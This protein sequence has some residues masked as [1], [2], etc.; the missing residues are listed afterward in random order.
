MSFPPANRAT[1]L[2]EAFRACDAGPLKGES[3]T[4]Y[5]VDLS[6]VRSA[7]TIQS[8]NTQLDFLEPGQF[9]A[10]A[11]TGHRGCG[12]STELRRLQQHWQT[13]YRVI[14]LEADEEL[15]ISDVEFVD[16]YLLTLKQV[17]DDLTQLDLMLGVPLQEEFESWLRD[18]T[19]ASADEF[20]DTTRRSLKSAVEQ[21]EVHPE[22]T[23]QISTLS[24]LLAKLLAQIKGLSQQRQVIRQTLEQT[25]DRLKFD[26]NCLLKH[27]DEKIRQ[28][29][30]KGFLLIFDNLD[31]VPLSV[32]ERLFFDSAIHLQELN[33][34]VVYTLPIAIVYSNKYLTNTVFHSNILPAVNVYAFEPFRRDLLFSKPSVQKLAMLLA[35]RMNIAAVFESERL[36]IQLVVASGGLVRQLLQMTATA[37]LTAASHGHAKVTADDIDYVLQQAQFNFE[38]VLSAHHYSILVQVCETKRIEQTQDG[39]LLLSNTAVLEYN[40]DRR[41]NYINPLIKQCD[42]FQ[43]A[44]KDSLEFQ[45]AI[46]QALYSDESTHS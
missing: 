44:L 18:V 35:Q 1:T 31:R 36:V 19:Q 25:I 37:C 33:C 12:K 24:T 16:I 23:A 11:L 34:T 2:K 38:R 5:Y 6:P 14:Y 13:S 21:S 10:V 43:K 40:G 26:I 8:L 27:A 22:K 46:E 30:P 32:G 4:Q 15:D 42:A 45:R 29:Y 20:E 17:I 41:W 28:I 39:Q 7:E 9:G 3:L